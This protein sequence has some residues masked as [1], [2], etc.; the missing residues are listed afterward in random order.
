VTAAPLRMAIVG[1]SGYA[2]G[3]MLRLALGHPH[4]EVVQVTSERHAGQPVAS[5]HPNLRS[6]TRLRFTPLDALED[7]D[8]LVSA[9]PHGHFAE[10]LDAFEARAE[11][12]VDLS[13][14][15]RLTDP[16]RYAR[17]Y[18][19]PHPAPDRLAGYVVAVPELHRADL[20]GA[21]RIAG[22][23]CLATAAQLALAPFLRTA[24]LAR[25]ETLIDA[26]IGS[27]AAGATP[28][29]ST[30]HPERAG[31]L[32]TYA[33]VGHRHEA[34]VAEALQG[35]LDVHLTA[36]AVPRVRGIL[37]TA[38]LWVQDGTSERDVLEAIR[39]AYDEEPFVRLVL[40]RRG[41]HRTPDPKLLD[42]TNWVDLGV[43]LDPD[44]GRLVVTTALDNL[45]K[46][47][48]GG[49]LQALNVA[50][51]FEETT[52]LTFPGLHP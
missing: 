35:R 41:V 16:D 3:E 45:V 24:I 34:E 29:P 18:G 50:R 11:T 26:K 38:H 32:R 27:S 51:G 14:D 7:A 48:A 1:A 9:L 8:V 28:G 25:R 44:S 52:G 5:V 21:T 19:A 49:A 47:T 13:S 10:H 31:A 36:T 23:G 20:V 40:A 12:V 30:H 37:A 33:P 15:M 17:T 42:G 22:A 4:L 43:A 39:E 6:L 46:G 2:G